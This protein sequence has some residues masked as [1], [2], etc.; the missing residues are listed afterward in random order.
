MIKETC[1]E[2][3]HDDGGREQVSNHSALPAL[4]IL[5]SRGPG[6]TFSTHFFFVVLSFVH[7]V[8]LVYR[9]VVVLFFPAMT[10]TNESLLRR[11]TG[12]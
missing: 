8:G 4:H 5:G 10:R 2:V 1:G 3:K 11:P 12:E 6:I 7:H 9:C